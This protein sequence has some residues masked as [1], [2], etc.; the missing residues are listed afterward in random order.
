MGRLYLIY[1]IADIPTSEPRVDN[2][3]EDVHHSTTISHYLQLDQLVVS[4]YGCMEYDLLHSDR[5]R[6]D[7][8]SLPIEWGCILGTTIFASISFDIKYIQGIFVSQFRGNRP[9]EWLMRDF[10][11]A[12]S[13]SPELALSFQRRLMNKDGNL[14]PLCMV[15]SFE[16]E[17]EEEEEDA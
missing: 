16:E 15:C 4:S 17:E 11:V 12:W 3:V 13:L 6:F 2:H 8:A 1:S 14:A 5:G 7:W 9:C 10:K